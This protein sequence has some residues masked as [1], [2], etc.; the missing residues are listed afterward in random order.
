MTKFLL[1]ISLI[2]YSLGAMAGHGEGKPQGGAGSKHKGNMIERLDQDGDGQ[3][4]IDEFSAAQQ[5]RADPAEIFSR[6]DQDGDGFISQSEMPQRRGEGRGGQ[7]GNMLQRLDQDGDG[8]LSMEE[9]SAV[10]HRRADPAERFSRIDQDG[11]GFISN[12]E[13]QKI[14]GQMRGRRH[15][16]GHHGRGP[17]DETKAAAEDT[18]ET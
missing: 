6:M 3:L 4:S 2:V 10:R 9:F 16:Q 11:D 1:V 12:A 14:R 5:R 8:L 7:R 15:G 17:A 13:I 18:T